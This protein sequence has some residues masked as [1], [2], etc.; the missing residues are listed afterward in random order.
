MTRSTFSPIQASMIFAALCI[1]L[2]IGV[3]EALFIA[4]GAP[5]FHIF[6]ACLSML[7]VGIIA[8]ALMF[9]LGVITE[10]HIDESRQIASFGL[11]LA[12]GWFMYFVMF[13]CFG[14]IGALLGVA[15]TLFET[16]GLPSAGASLVFARKIGAACVL[17]SLFP[18]LIMT[19]AT[20]LGFKPIDT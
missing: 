14:L 13:L 19:V 18:P 10:F 5:P 17:C 15:R 16:G 20:K 6:V 7:L 2:S 11:A 12:L 8:M 9:E 1:A 3:S 4:G